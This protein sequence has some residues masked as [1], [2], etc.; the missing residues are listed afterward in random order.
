MNVLRKAAVLQRWPNLLIA[1]AALISS[2]NVMAQGSRLPEWLDE[3][4]YLSGLL[5]LHTD[6]DARHREAIR[7]K[8]TELIAAAIRQSPTAIEADLL[9]S[10]AKQEV[11]S[12]ARGTSPQ[13][14]VSGQNTYTQTDAGLTSPANGKTGLLVQMQMPLYDS[15]RT[16]NAIQSREALLASQKAK[17]EVQ[18]IG[19]AQEV[20]AACANHTLQQILLSVNQIHA[21]R[22]TKL[23]ETISEIATI[24]PGRASELTQAKSRQ[25]QAELTLQTLQ[26]KITE[27]TA[28]LERLLKSPERYDCL[29]GLKYFIG[30]ESTENYVSNA[31]VHPQ[32]IAT[33]MEAQ[34]QLAFASQIKASR[35]PLVQLG[36]G[37]SPVNLALSNEYQNSIAVT[38][39]IPIYDGFAADKSADAATQRGAAAN[40][41]AEAQKEKIQSDLK[42]KTAAAKNAAR[43]LE[44]YT[45]LLKVSRKVREDYYIQWSTLGR[46]SLFELLAI[47]S[48]QLS[49]QS[50]YVSSLVDLISSNAY[51]QVQTGNLLKELK[52]DQDEN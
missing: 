39:T 4:A 16:S 43:R 11:E 9:I 2:A 33:Q 8:L 44:K 12:A 21:T 34:S 22:M 23:T 27:T 1:I 51:Q 46:R 20:I 45:E 35:K 38:A 42:I 28:E 47:E 3:D 41:R 24:D 19:I 30:D 13:I 15:G 26:G 10:S 29:E 17:R 37:R 52:L 7:N 18:Y 48:E 31:E 32:V 40:A 14:S 6:K 49:L 36:I 50:N 5:D 25:L